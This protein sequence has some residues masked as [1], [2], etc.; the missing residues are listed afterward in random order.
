MII[1]Y[2]RKEIT[3]Q[4]QNNQY[5]ICLEYRNILNKKYGKSYISFD[6][7]GLIY[8]VIY[9][10]SLEKI[11]CFLGNYSKEQILEQIKKDNVLYFLSEVKDT[12]DIKFSIRYYDM[13]T[14]K[15]RVS[16]PVLQK[17]CY[18]F[19]LEKYFKNYLNENDRKRIYNKL[20]GYLTNQ[21]LLS[22]TKVFIQHFQSLTPEELWR[23][24]LTLPYIEQR[25]IK[26][27][28][29]ENIPI[30]LQINLQRNDTL[31]KHVLKKEKA[32]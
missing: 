19:D 25:K 4:E 18:H 21:H 30:N 22:P 15:E 12:N 14:K 6:E 27:V 8:D 9:R 26:L 20:G 1:S 32:A 5:Y 31:K 10:Y 2:F 11:D 24:F 16:V 23:E 7:N 28:I 29:Y 13:T 17:D 3:M